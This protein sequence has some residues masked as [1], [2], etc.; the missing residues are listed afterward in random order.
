MSKEA[1][2]TG[3]DQLEAEQELESRGTN[4]S[5][6]PTS[7]AFQTFIASGWAERDANLP[8]TA[9]VAPFAALRRAAVA[10]A[11]AGKVIIIES[12]AAKTRSNDTE[13]MYR[14]HSA[15]AHLTGWGTDSVPDSVLVIDARGAAG[16]TEATLFFRETAGRDSDE[17]FANPAIGEFWVGAR[18]SLAQ[19]GS[20]LALHTRTLKDFSAYREALPSNDVVDLSDEALVEFVSELRLIKDSFEIAQMREAVAASVTGFEAVV[21]S[22]PRAVAA[23]RGERVVEGAFFAEARALGNNL[24]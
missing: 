11:F 18:P 13:Y 20:L 2:E 8:A 3:S 4:R 9:E 1:H 12:G 5:R 23:T 19:V 15:F 14:P 7:E 24:G 10:A 16:A 17:F 22:L 21:R 6:T